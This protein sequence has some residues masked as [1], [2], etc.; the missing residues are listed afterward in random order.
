MKKSNLV[1]MSNPVRGKA[2]N[3]HHL[4]LNPSITH[5]NLSLSDLK[6]SLLHPPRSRRLSDHSLPSIPHLHPYS[7][8]QEETL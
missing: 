5:R 1:K 8:G 2:L 6:I 4:Q 7:V 3:S